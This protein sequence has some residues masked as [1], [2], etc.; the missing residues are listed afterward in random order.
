MTT[1]V[2]ERTR[3]NSDQS[4]SNMAKATNATSEIEQAL[5]GKRRRKRRQCDFATYQQ[6]I[7]STIDKLKEQMNAAEAR[8]EV[9]ESRRL[10]NLIS[11]YESRLLKRAKDEDTQAQIDVR[12]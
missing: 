10:K 9:K 8:K 11:A 12:T 4:Q 7:F 6:E 1:E 3:V 5:L 2:Q